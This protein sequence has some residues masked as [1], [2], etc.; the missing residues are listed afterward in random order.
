MGKDKNTIIYDLFL[1][2]KTERAILVRNIEGTE[3]WIPN[4]MIVDKFIGD[5][6]FDE[7]TKRNIYKLESL[8]L[9]E[10]IAKKNKFI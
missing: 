7:K 3:A 6:I 4:S 10:W 8:E 5:Q 1:V 2:H 9:P